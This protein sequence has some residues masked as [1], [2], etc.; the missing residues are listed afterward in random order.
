MS[1]QNRSQVLEAIT[2]PLGFFVLALLIVEAFLA[3][4]L[5]GTTL[6]NEHK[7]T[8]MYLGVVLFIFVT[9]IVALLVWFKPDHLTFDK[10]AHLRSQGKPPFGSD[11]VGEAIPQNLA[12]SNKAT[13]QS[14]K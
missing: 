13:Q 1:K 7:V 11:E 12:P 14:N 9:L 4:I 6:E 10:E 8:G 3:T 2:A 5:V